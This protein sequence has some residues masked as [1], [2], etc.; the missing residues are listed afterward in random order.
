MDCPSCGYDNIP[1]ADEC[2][3]CHT[4]LTQ[5]D[6]P[7]DEASGRIERSVIEDRVSDLHPAEPICVTEDTSVESA[8]AT[9][10]SKRIGCLLVTGAD[11]ALTGIVTERDLLLKITGETD[12]AQQTVRELMTPAPETI[13]N[14]QLLAHALQLMMVGDHRHLPV[15]APDG[16][17]IGIVSSRDII[18]HLA[19]LIGVSGTTIDG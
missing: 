2:A 8:V 9:M 16:R 19:S 4:S 3:Q 14:D 17:P 6:I 7:R 12:L 11:A 1:G 15:V 10:R 13:R 5:E 18:G